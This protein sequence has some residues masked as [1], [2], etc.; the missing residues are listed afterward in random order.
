VSSL[1]SSEDS[2]ETCRKDV[3]GSKEEGAFEEVDVN[4]L[5][6]SLLVIHGLL[7]S[8]FGRNCLDWARGAVVVENE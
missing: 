7:E 8:F 4:R 2:W 5:G 1:R 6:V 3:S